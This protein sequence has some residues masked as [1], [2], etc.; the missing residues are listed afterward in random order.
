MYMIVVFF[1]AMFALYETGCLKTRP[2]KLIIL[3]HFTAVY[4]TSIY[5]NRAYMTALCA[6]AVSALDKIECFGHK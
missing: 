4:L 1:A 2:V 6:I 3:V 5:M